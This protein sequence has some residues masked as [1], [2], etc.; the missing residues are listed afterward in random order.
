[1]ATIAVARAAR[2]QRLAEDQLDVRR[3]HRR[4]RR[5]G[6]GRMLAQRLGAAARRAGAH[7][8]ARRVGARRRRGL[9]CDLVR[10]LAALARRPRRAR[11]EERDRAGAHRPARAAAR[12]ARSRAARANAPRPPCPAYA[13][14]NR[15]VADAFAARASRTRRARRVAA[16]YRA[17]KIAPFDGVIAEDAAR[18]RSTRGRAPDSTACSRCATPSARRR[19]AWSTATGASTSPRAR[20]LV[21]RH[22]DGEAP[23]WVECMISEHPRGFGAIA[24]LTRSSRTSAA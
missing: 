1:M 6:L 2:R 14:I 3:R 24:R 20:A 16:G 21:A 5:D 4:R 9:R 12:A 7:A 18:H 23:Y 11:G 13:N 10:Y 19:R 22:R 8:R 17:V 15:G